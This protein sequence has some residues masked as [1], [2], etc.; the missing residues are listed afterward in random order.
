MTHI[1]RSS[2]YGFTRAVEGL[3]FFNDGFPPANKHPSDSIGI[4]SSRMRR[5]GPVSEARKHHSIELLMQFQ[6]RPVPSL[7]M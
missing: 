4:D 1:E 3:Q 7:A 5:L 6:S 2:T